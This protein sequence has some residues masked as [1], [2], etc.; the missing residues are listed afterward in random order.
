MT[1]FDLKEMKSSLKNNNT[2][3]SNKN[4]KN[5]K[6]K[7]I[8][9]FSQFLNIF[10]FIML[11]VFA[12]SLFSNYFIQ[13]KDREEVK[14]SMSELVKNIQNAV[15][16][17]SASSSS[18][19]KN[20]FIDG[21]KIYLEK[22]EGT[23]LVSLKEKNETFL[24]ILKNY[25]V[26]STTLESLNIQV[27]EEN[28]IDFLTLAFIFLPIIFFGIILWSLLRGVKGANMNALSFG[29]TKA[30]LINPNDNKKKITF[31]DVAGAKEAKEE[32]E[33]VVDFLKSPKKFL[34]IGAKIP[35]GLLLMGAPGTGKTLLARAVAGEAG[36]PFYHLSGSEFVEMFVGVGASR[37]RDLFKEAK[38]NSPAIIFIDEIDAVG[39]SRGIGLGGGNDEREQTLNQILVEMDGFEPNEKLIV[40]A[41]TNRPDVL[42][43]ALLR[44][45][46]FD[47]RVT[48]DLP[49]RESREDILQVHSKG[50]P[51]AEDVNLKVVAERTPGFSGADLASI[52]NEAAILAA[53]EGRKLISQYDLIR[54]IE[55]VMLGPERKTH[56]LSEKEKEKTAYHEAGHALVAS[57]LPNADP[58]HKISIISRGNAGGY[59]LKL[60]IDDKKLNTEKDFIDDIAMAFGGYAAELEVYGNLSTGPSNDLQVITSMARDMVMKYGMNKKVGPIAIENDER[61]VVYGNLADSKNIIGD[62]LANAVDD[63][64]KKICEEGLETA[65][66]IVKEKRGVLDCIAKELMEKENLE[67][68]EFEN[69]LILHGIAVKK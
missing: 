44:P 38:R 67:R 36:V 57:M 69:I 4:Q 62:N 35:K 55:K 61:K 68:E 14:I 21:D 22:G 54:S 63:E 16:A 12:Y 42:D 51:L 37:V 43:R 65:K 1:K 56:I 10:V 47:R 50:K 25:D 5:K 29:N 41:A 59:T 24:D 53:R 2:E 34:E 19:I 33:E 64:I 18:A 31:K 6:K 66:K 11:L 39:R 46:R 27:K 58:V 28:K 60:P 15:D 13:N 40:I 7:P 23:M 48:I 26:S 8:N 45:G 17:E 30:K 3:K 52:M 20:I 32:L 49:D 9:L